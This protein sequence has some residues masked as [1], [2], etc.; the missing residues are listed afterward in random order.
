M[1]KQSL[2][3]LLDEYYI[4]G[5]GL[6]PKIDIQKPKQKSKEELQEEIKKIEKYLSELKSSERN[7]KC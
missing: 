4:L 2:N 7:E 3:N 1:T 5:K 6:F